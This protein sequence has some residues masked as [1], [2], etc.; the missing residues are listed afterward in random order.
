MEASVRG[1][2]MG[3]GLV[4]ERTLRTKIGDGRKRI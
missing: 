3:T 4:D 1:K 2:M